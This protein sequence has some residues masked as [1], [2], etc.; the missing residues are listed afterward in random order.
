MIKKIPKEEYDKFWK[1]YSTNMKLGTIEDAQNR[2]RLSKLLRF[3]SSKES[4]TYTSLAEYVERMKPSQ[5]H[6]YYIA[7]SSLD[8]V[9]KSPFVERLLKSGYEVLYLIEAVDEYALSSL[10]EF[11]GKKFQNVA[12]EGFSLDEDESE[13]KEKKEELKKT[14]EPLI[15]YLNKV[16][17][18]QI[19]KAQLSERLTDSSCALVASTFGWTGN[20]ERLAISN[21]HQ[22]A[23]DPQKMYYLNQKKTLEINPEHPIV[24]NL[25]DKVNE[26][27]DDPAN[28][29]IAK[30]LFQLATLRSG[31]MLR[32]TSLFAK[33]VEEL[34]KQNLGV[35]S[36]FSDEETEANHDE[37]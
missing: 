31:F 7:G 26:N 19:S 32:E 3:K 23:E 30:M 15:E 14:Y 22:K 36:G 16:L 35:Y 12:K 34:M 10:P 6:I 29:K 1:E 24:K 8:E 28:E 27:K 21:A 11:E 33:N 37:L 2:A 9:K 5:Q 4:T 25:L 18:D 20:M 17:K 13:N